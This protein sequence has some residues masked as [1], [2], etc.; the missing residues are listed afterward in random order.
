M[1]SYNIL[2]QPSSFMNLAMKFSSPVPLELILT[3]TM[4][5]AQAY[6]T[7]VI[8]S[9]SLYTSPLGCQTR[10]IALDQNRLSFV[11]TAYSSQYP[12]I[13]ILSLFSWVNSK[14]PLCILILLDRKVRDLVT[15]AKIKKKNFFGCY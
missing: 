5:F 13:E 6:L 11:S 4:S 3:R 8:K 10:W 15:V 2:Q 14:K 9:F 1:F 12:R 7:V